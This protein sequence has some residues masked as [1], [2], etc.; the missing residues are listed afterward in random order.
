LGAF[1]RTKNEADPVLPWLSVARQVTIVIPTGK[2]VP[3][4][5]V[6]VTGSGPS[7]ASTA[8][9]VK[10]TTAP[11]LLGAVT[12]MLAGTVTSGGVVSDPPAA[13]TVTVKV[14]EPAFPCASVAEQVTLVVPTGK[15]DPEAGTQLTG[16]GP[17]TT[18]VADAPKVNGAPE[19]PVAGKVAFAGTVTTGAVESR[20]VTANVAVAALPRV[21]YAVQ[22]TVV[23]ATGKVVPDAGAQDTGRGPS[24]RSAAELAKVTIAPAGPVASTVMFA[25]TVRAG[26]VVSRTV[27]VKPPEAVLPARSVDEQATV[28]VPM[29]NTDPDGGVHVTGRAPS[30]TSVAVALKLTATPA[31][32]AAS[33]VRSA[34]RVRTGAEESLTAMVKVP[35]AG[36]PAASV[37]VH[38]TVVVPMGNVEPDIGVQLGVSGP[39]TASSAVA[40][41][42]AT[43][44]E[45]L[46]AARV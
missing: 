14:R 38:V 35:E 31:L 25:G 28:L 3:L 27:M 10:L 8:V 46:V 29:A 43:A 4:G 32:L 1:T 2:R 36:F 12:M 44:P 21:S 24:T 15:V 39:S 33:R 5:G 6:H 45:L 17:S 40:V 41:K 19:G 9:A 37:A 26:A 7:T 16:K 34:G 13:V 20:T 23:V 18:S 42:V 30:T 22:L 11:V